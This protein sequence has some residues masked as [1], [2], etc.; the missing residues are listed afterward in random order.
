MKK[1]N[2]LS[3]KSSLLNIKSQLFTG[4]KPSSIKPSQSLRSLIPQSKS[5]LSE[6]NA[7]IVM[8]SEKLNAKFMKIT[9]K[10]NWGHPTTL[11]V[12]SIVIFSDNHQRVPILYNSIIPPSSEYPP[13]CGLFNANLINECA[14]RTWS[15]PW[16]SENKE[17]VTIVVIVPI[18][19]KVKF[20]RIWNDKFDDT[21]SVREVQISTSD[22]LL[23][24]GEIPLGFGTDIHLLEK[25]SPSQSSRTLYE[26]FPQLD[27]TQILKDKYGVYPSIKVFDIKL[28]IISSFINEEFVGLNAILIFDENLEQIL[29]NDIDEFLVSNANYKSNPIDLFRSKKDIIV[30]QSSKMF[31]MKTDWVLPPIINIKLKNPKQISKIEIWNFNAIELNLNTGIKK[32][33]INLNDLLYWQGLIKIGNG[34]IKNVSN[35]FTSIWFNDIPSIRIKRNVK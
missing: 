30:S 29:W 23:S 26:I 14:G 24:E 5:S 31:I 21:A 20:V 11:A 32:A 8:K 3:K 4:Q 17:G 13:L 34:S 15:I 1:I 28:E 2:P 7:S 12:A 35:T 16:N 18:D 10:S 6:S 19:T 27:Q 33:K 9:L 25:I 22:G